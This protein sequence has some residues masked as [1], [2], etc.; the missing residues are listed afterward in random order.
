[1]IDERATSTGQRCV[2]HIS[3]P[4]TQNHYSLSSCLTF[5]CDG[6]NRVASNITQ[7][8]VGSSKSSAAGSMLVIEPTLHEG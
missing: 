4:R 7:D 8:Q 3:C 2:E 1:M 6:L 5:P